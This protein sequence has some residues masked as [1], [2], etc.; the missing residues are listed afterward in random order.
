MKLGRKVISLWYHQ[1]TE[2]KAVYIFILALC[3]DVWK[4]HT[5]ESPD[6]SM[7]VGILLHVIHFYFVL[8]YLKKVLHC[9]TCSWGLEQIVTDQGW[10]Q[11]TVL[12]C[13]VAHWLLERHFPFTNQMKADC[14]KWTLLY[15]LQQWLALQHKWTGDDSYGLRPWQEFCEVHEI[16]I[17]MYLLSFSSYSSTPG[18][19]VSLGD[20]P[21][22]AGL[23]FRTK[24][25]LATR[26]SLHLSGGERLECLP[27]AMN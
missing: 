8:F 10:K 13:F 18:D 27:A 1:Y 17:L 5:Y 14:N 12:V 9:S 19:T 25:L 15:L 7:Y 3:W 4:S 24:S 2:D 6:N 22:C 16:L 11:Y 20:W 23:I 21:V 26:H